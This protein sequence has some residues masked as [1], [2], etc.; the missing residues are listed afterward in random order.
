M[1]PNRNARRW[2]DFKEA[3]TS[4]LV[5]AG[6]VLFWGGCWWGCRALEVQLCVLTGGERETCATAAAVKGGRRR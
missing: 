2:Q 6:L 4:L 5:L 3:L 1:T